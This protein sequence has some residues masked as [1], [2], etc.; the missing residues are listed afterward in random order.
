[1]ETNLFLPVTIDENGINIMRCAQV[2]DFETIDT[3]DQTD[4]SGLFEMEPMNELR[5]GHDV[6][7]YTI[8][9]SV[10]EENEPT[11]WYA[12]VGD[13]GHQMAVVCFA[14]VVVVVAKHSEGH[15][16]CAPTPVHVQ[17]QVHCIG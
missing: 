1:M 11:I 3:A 5:V 8:V 14:V 4:D 7:L 9:K 17:V 16:L 12:Q 13:A 2:W 15:L 6:Q 10:D